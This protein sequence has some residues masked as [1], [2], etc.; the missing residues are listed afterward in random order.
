MAFSRTLQHF[1]SSQD[2]ATVWAS[3]Q[4]Y[5]ANQLVI[6]NYSIYICIIGHTST[7][8][9]PND[10]NSG[11]WAQI[12]GASGANR[13]LNI[14]SVNKTLTNGDSVI[15]VN[16]A[17]APVTIT[18]PASI[19][20]KYFD[21]KK[22]DATANAVTIVPTSG[23]IDGGA[24]VVITVQYNSVTVIGDGTNFAII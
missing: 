15:L 23:T 14:Y 7:S 22:I 17:A 24:S 2:L 8:S 12:T 9:F 10:F 20:G 4:A 3:G 18:L 16:A 5:I 11:K 19:S 13:E 6:Y 21:I 1:T